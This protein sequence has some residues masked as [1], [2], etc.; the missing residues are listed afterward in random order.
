MKIGLNGKAP[1]GK[2]D[3]KKDGE[4]EEDTRKTEDIGGTRES[5]EEV[6][7]RYSTRERRAPGEWYR[8]NMAAEGKETEPQTCKEALAE[9]DAEL[10]RRA[11]DE[12]FASLLENGT[13]TGA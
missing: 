7:K 8:A 11:M 6:E 4:V 9:P 13:S 2:E 5:G 1:N 10:W 12:E 3:E